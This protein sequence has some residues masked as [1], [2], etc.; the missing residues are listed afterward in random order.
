IHVEKSR[1]GTETRWR[2]V[3]CAALVGRDERSIE[4]RFF[5]GIGTGLALCVNAAGPV[6]FYKFR[7][8]DVLAGGAIEHEIPSVA[9]GLCQQL[10][11]CTIDVAFEGNW[12]LDR[13]PV[14]R[15]VR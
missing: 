4:L 13:L 5:F 10:A 1:V 6:R 15:V 11:A 9:A 14:M 12:R 7:A 2:P 3:H 8:D